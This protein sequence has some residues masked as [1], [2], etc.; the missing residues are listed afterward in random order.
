MSEKT[1]YLDRD[2]ER[3]TGARMTISSDHANIHAGEGFQFQISAEAVADDG[4]VIVEMTTGST[5][6]VHMKQL[7]P[8]S[9]GG[10]A[11]IDILE[12]N[13]SSGGSAGAPINKW[14]AGTPQATSVTLKTGTTPSA[15]TAIQPALM[16][17]G[18]GA[19]LGVAGSMTM[20]NEWVLARSTIYTFRVKNLAGAAKA[21][22]LYL[23]WYE[24]DEA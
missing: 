15:G 4:T 12:A 18:G 6:Y 10:V 14:R 3:V 2:R 11:S 16:F 24:E 9:E 13:T 19:G 5:K 17:G 22:S 20:D 1:Q 21:L 23:F 7:I 8:W